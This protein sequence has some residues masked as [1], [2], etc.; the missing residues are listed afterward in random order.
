MSNHDIAQAMRH[1]HA[2]MVDKLHQLTQQ[3][4][5]ASNWKFTRDIVTQWITT[6]IVRQAL[7]EE[8]TVYPVARR[9]N[10]Q[11]I[12]LML[13]DHVALHTLTTELERSD[14]RD[15]ALMAC[16]Q[17]SHLFESH[18]DKENRFIIS[19]IESLSD[20]NLEVVLG[21]MHQLL[22]P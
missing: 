5:M 9:I 12:E 20:V 8:T 3:M 22:A 17:I 1:H 2:E 19:P 11:L 7:A 18:V 15:A 14:T 6:E 13:Y 21:E 10:Y 16:A 4:V